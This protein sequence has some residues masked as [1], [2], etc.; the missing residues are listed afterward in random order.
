MPPRACRKIRDGATP[1]HI[2]WSVVRRTSSAVA[3]A[4]AALIIAGV[5]AI[6]LAT[7]EVQ[8]VDPGALLTALVVPSPSCCSRRIFRHAGPPALTP[9]DSGRSRPS[10][11]RLCPPSPGCRPSTRDWRSSNHVLHQLRRR[12]DGAASAQWPESG[13]RTADGARVP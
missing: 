8:P 4:V 11:R 13:R 3:G 7:F 5:V 1:A 6:A 2:F 12:A 9:Q 10:R